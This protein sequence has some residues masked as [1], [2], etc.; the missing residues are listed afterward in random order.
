M[1]AFTPSEMRASADT[2]APHYQEGSVRALLDTDLITPATRAVLLER[3]APHADS[4]PRFFDAREWATLCA[5]CR[6][7]IPQPERAAPIQLP[8]DIDERLADDKADGWRYDVLPSDPEAYR[9]GLRGIDETAEAVFGAPFTTLDATQQDAVLHAVQAGTAPGPTWSALPPKLFFEELL[10]EIT[11]SYYSHPLAFEEIGFAGMADAHG[12]QTVGL[13][14]RAAFEPVPRVSAATA[15][16][17]TVSATIPHVVVDAQHQDAFVAGCEPGASA[18]RYAPSE[19]VDALVVGT[20]AGGAPLI[21]RLAR[22]GLKV[23]ALE[24]GRRWDPAKDFA[25]DE[26]A[27]SKLYWSDERLSAGRDPTHFGRNNSGIGVG[28]STLHYTAYVPRPQPDD[29][30]LRSEF[31]VGAD[32]PLT[33]AQ[34]EPYFEEVERT[35]GVSG[36][37]SYPWGPPRR[38]SYPLAPL[39]LNGAAQLMERGCA[40][41]GI[42]TSPAANAALSGSYYQPGIGWRAACTNRGFC[43]AGCTTG[44]KASMDVTFLP[45]AV[46]AGAEIRAECFATRIETD[47]RGR[48]TAVVYHHGGVEHRQRCR[49]VFLCAGAVE[50]PRLLLLN[51]LANDSGQVGRNFMAH[52]GL[53]LW[54]RFA[55]EIR[56]FKGIPGALIS[57]DMHRARDADFV[58]GYLLQSI[59]VLPVTYASQVARGRG[60]WGEPLRAHMRTY[61][62]TAGINVLGD[63]L[64]YDENFLELSNE[65]DAR[66]LQKPRIHFSLGENECRMRD[67][68]E[69]SMRRIWA[70]AG[71]ADVWTYSRT[72]HTIGTCRMGTDPAAA[73]V[74][75]DCRVFDV[76]G[77]YVCDNSV[78]PSALSVN[79]ALTIMALSLRTADRF[80]ARA[81]EGVAA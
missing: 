41:L 12:W 52:V 30:R 25:T 15:S 73:V 64:P 26:R 54:G 3:L 50:T 5:M 11:E 65:L 48:V 81:R 21:A 61:N 60:L 38:T 13:G 55:D 2:S 77:L 32:W 40:T 58:G 78:F 57:E 17:V 14:A 18:W 22:A 20:G 39:P 23:V 37:A 46:A 4:P 42:Q 36:P 19:E 74:D 44:A 31:G 62:H 1:D 68:A 28:G 35:L 67:H 76:P 6:R 63:C 79:P 70:A 72:A 75:A 10:A 29:F 47:A 27:Q 59:G 7:L 51:S 9:R 43:E 66:G 53:Q 24:A 8:A 56:P 80:L 34:L 71:A 33:Y 16:A 49:A 45:L 69:R